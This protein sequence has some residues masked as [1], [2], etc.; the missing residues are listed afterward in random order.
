MLGAPAA[1]ANPWAP[2]CV[3]SAGAR[4]LGA[5]RQGGP[6]RAAIPGLGANTSRRPFDP[7]WSPSPGLG[8]PGRRDS[9]LSPDFHLLCDLGSRSPRSFCICRSWIKNPGSSPGS[10]EPRKWAL[11]ADPPPLCLSPD[12]FLI[13][14]GKPLL[15]N[16]APSA[17]V[18]AQRVL[19]AACL[20]FSGFLFVH[21]N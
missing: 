19:E 21:R 20:L 15:G 12:P 10:L 7:T 18:W 14:L 8:R 1:G 2:I 16:S 13:Q 17:S 9:S 3:T 6:A 11:W 5:R 4:S